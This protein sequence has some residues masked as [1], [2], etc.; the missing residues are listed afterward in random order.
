VCAAVIFSV[1]PLRAST[2][3]FSDEYYISSLS[4]FHSVFGASANGYSSAGIYQETN[5]VLPVITR[6]GNGS[7][8]TGEYVQNTTPNLNQELV[9]FGW[10]QSLNNGQQVA[11]VYN[12]QNPQN[13]ADLYFRFDVGGS[14]T[15]FNFN[16]FDLKGSSATSNLS[17]TLEG[18]DASNN[19]INSTVLNIQGNTFTTETLNWAGVT[20]V[21]LVSTAS[22]PVNW[23]SASLYMD[24]VTINNPLPPVPEPT[25]LALLGLG[26]LML[27]L[28]YQN[29][30]PQHSRSAKRNRI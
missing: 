13:G 27:G 4:Q 15:S 12:T 30:R 8:V 14:A 9:L 17:F 23:N 22:L 16:S 29:R 5:S 25:S 28:V 1:V 7:S 19:V 21:E 11:N 2:F 3:S 18:L 10:G 26:L 24:N 20:T 6:L